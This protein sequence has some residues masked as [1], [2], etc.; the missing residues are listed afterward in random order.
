M[1]DSPGLEKQ[2]ALIF[3]EAWATRA[4][5]KAPEPEELILGN[6]AVVFDAAT[7]L[8]ADLTGSTHLVDSEDWTFAAEIYKAYLHCA[9]TI[10]RSEGGAIVS[11]DGDRIMGVFIGDVQATPAARSGLKINHAVQK[12]IN[13]ALAAQYPLKPFRV[14]QVV[15]IDTSPI[16]AARTGVRGHNDL[17]WIGRAANYAAKLTDLKLA[18]R[19]W[20]T[21]ASYDRLHEDLKTNGSPRQSMWKP[22]SWSQ[23][24]NHQ[25]YGSTWT[26]TA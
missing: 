6:Q 1:T 12:I 26:W 14:S 20:L 11:Y 5:Q 10:I 7:I 13:P 24:N 15:G 4:G 9:A 3:K 21:K 2:V 16:R 17:V 23:M 18:E 25:I 22:Y 19:T 8:Y